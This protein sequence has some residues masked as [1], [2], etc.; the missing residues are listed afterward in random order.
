MCGRAYQPRFL[1]MWPNARISVMGGNQ[2]ANV[3]ATVK[4]DKL[5]K[6]NQKISDEEIENLKRPIIDKYEK[7]GSPYYSSSRLWDDGIIDPIETRDILIMALKVVRNTNSLKKT[8]V[9]RM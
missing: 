6:K 2:A 5:L 7:E 3:M 8:P 4:E 9:F 1:W